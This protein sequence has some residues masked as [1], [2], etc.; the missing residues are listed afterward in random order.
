M[1]TIADIGSKRLEKVLVKDKTED[2]KRL[3]EILK[4]D[5]LNLLQNYME[6]EN[7][8]VN[9]DVGL[10][11]YKFSIDVEAKRIKVFGILPNK[12]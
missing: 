7:L 12:S 2:P 11:G 1:F 9:F 4:S 10:D 8:N 6:V 3:A 5:V